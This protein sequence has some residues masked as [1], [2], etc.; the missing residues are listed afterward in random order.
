MAP[1]TTSH[2]KTNLLPR[3]NSIFGANLRNSYTFLSHTFYLHNPDCL[4]SKFQDGWLWLIK[5]VL[6]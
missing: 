1:E 4:I 5:Y 6:N 3:M 2:V